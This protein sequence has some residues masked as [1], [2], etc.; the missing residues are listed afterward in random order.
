MMNFYDKNAPPEVVTDASPVGLGAILV[1]EQQGEKRAVA[2]AS[3]SLS[4]VEHCYSQTEKEALA[5]VGG[6]ERFSL[7]LLGLESFQFVN[8]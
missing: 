1:Q 2:F 6:C 5:V 3:P 7:Y 4:E 8:Y